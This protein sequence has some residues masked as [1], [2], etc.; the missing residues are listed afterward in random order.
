MY[1]AKASKI[2]NKPMKNDDPKSKLI[3]MLKR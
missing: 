1:A 2:S 3:E